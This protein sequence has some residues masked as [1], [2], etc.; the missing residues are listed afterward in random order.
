[1]AG[2][3]SRA[4]ADTTKRRRSGPPDE[5]RWWDPGDQAFIQQPL[6]S[7]HD[8][9][10]GWQ[11]TTMLNNSEQLDPYEGADAPRI[12]AARAARVLSALDE[13]VAYRTRHGQLLVLR[14]EV[15]VD[16]AETAHRAA[17]QAD[18]PA[19]LTSTYRAR[20]AERDVVPNWIE[21]TIAP[22]T[23]RP[24][25]LDP[26]IDWLRVEDHTDPKGSG[27]VTIYEHLTLWCG[28]A[29]AVITVRHEPDEPVREV[30]YDIG[31]T[32]LRRLESV[33]ARGGRPNGAS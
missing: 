19:V 1:V 26:R 24:A 32:L 6:L 2:R 31:H 22:M 33:P 21:T 16:P 7:R 9:P 27:I 15:F 29:N 20:W 8:F 30:A 18:G 23:A 25:E 14:A 10:K 5:H 12:R 28:R 3:R 4:R 11:P 13:G 17:W